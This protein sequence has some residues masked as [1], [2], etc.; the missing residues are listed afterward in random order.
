MSGENVPARVRDAMK[1]H[2]VALV[3]GKVVTFTDVLDYCPG[4]ES[5]VPS[6]MGQIKEASVT[7]EGSDGQRYT[8]FEGGKITDDNDREVGQTAGFNP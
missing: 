5:A 2:Q 6:Q 8:V 7:V 4:G 1:G 3:G